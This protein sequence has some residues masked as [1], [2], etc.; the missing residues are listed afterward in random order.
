MVKPI[1]GFFRPAVIDQV[2]TKGHDKGRPT[3]NTMF[4]KSLY[5]GLLATTVANFNSTY[6]GFYGF[7]RGALD[8][9]FAL[10]QESF[11]EQVLE[12]DMREIKR[13][14]ALKAI[15]IAVNFFTSVTLLYVTC[16]FGELIYW[17]GKSLVGRA[18]YRPFGILDLLKIEGMFALFTVGIDIGLK[19]VDNM[20]ISNNRSSSRQHYHERP[21]FDPESSQYD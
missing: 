9:P 13:E 18:T 12:A 16:K 14:P 4:H 5:H 10:I 8:L 17:G 11:F 21:D 1:D 19:I 6:A 15:Y 3:F 7:L 2:F 20:V